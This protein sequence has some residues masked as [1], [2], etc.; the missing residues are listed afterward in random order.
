MYRRRIGIFAAVAMVSCAMAAAA[1]AQVMGSLMNFI[2][3]CQSE[4][5]PSLDS[6]LG[7]DEGSA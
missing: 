3:D 4:S 7:F 1:S 2:S 6:V 5:V